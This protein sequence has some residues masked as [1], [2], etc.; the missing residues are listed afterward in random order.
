MATASIFPAQAHPPSALAGRVRAALEAPPAEA[1]E[2]PLRAFQNFPRPEVADVRRHGGCD[3]RPLDKRSCIFAND[4]LVWAETREAAT[5]F[6]PAFP[7]WGRCEDS[8]RSDVRLSD[9]TDG[10]HPHLS[11]KCV[12]SKAEVGIR[13]GPF[14][15]LGLPR[16]GKFCVK[17]GG[18]LG[19]WTLVQPTQGQVAAWPVPRGSAS[20]L[21]RSR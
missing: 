16:S 15:S 9:P 1:L 10:P 3:Q 21:T 7:L 8:V 6:G 18:S 5:T 19:P 4:P 20:G 11:S 2:E 13:G 17:R 14:G 12:P